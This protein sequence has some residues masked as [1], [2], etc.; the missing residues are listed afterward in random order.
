MLNITVFNL[1]E[2]SNETGHENKAQDDEDIRR[3]C[4]SIG[5]EEIEIVTL[6]RLGKKKQNKTRPTKIILSNKTQRKAILN[7]EKHI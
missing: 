1:E 7:N 3:I 5:V 6:Y 4:S 2:H